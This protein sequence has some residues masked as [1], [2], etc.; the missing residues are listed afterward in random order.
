VL[1]AGGLTLVLLAVGALASVRHSNSSRPGPALDSQLVAVLPFRVSSGDSALSY[2]GE[3]F[4]DLLAVQLTG[5]GGL[6]AAEPRNVLEAW[7]RETAGDLDAEPGFRAGLNV[8]RKIGA[9]R[10]VDGSITGTPHHVVVSAL[11]LETPSGTSVGRA[12]VEGPLE[13]LGELVNR[14][15]AELL[16]TQA[17]ERQRLNDLSVLSL[18]ALRPY[19]EGQAALRQGRWDVAAQ[20]FDAALDVDSTFAQA[21]LGLAEAAEWQAAGDG[22]KGERLA[23]AHRDRLSPG[24]RELLGVHLGP[25]YPGLST[26]AEMIAAAERGVKA[27]PNQPGAWFRLGDRYYHW[28]A[29]IG[30]SHARQLAATAFRRAIQLDSSI[31]RNAPKAEPLTHLFQ[32]AA[33]EGDTATVRR[34][35]PPVPAADSGPGSFPWRAAWVFHD[36]SAIEAIH[37]RFAAGDVNGLEG[38]MTRTLEDG[39]PLNEA[40][41][42]VAALEA[43]A[44][45]QGEQARAQYARYMVAISGGRPMEAVAALRDL[46]P[47]TRFYHGITG[48]LYWDGDTA[49]ARAIARAGAVRADAPLTQVPR[50]LGSQFWQMCWV[51]RWRVAHG[52]LARAGKTIARLRS[53]VTLWQDVADSA[54]TSG[55]G[56]LCADLLEATVATI[57]HRPGAALL[58]TRLN[59]RLRTVP[60]GWTDGDNLAVAHLLE[61]HGNVAEALAAVRRRRFDLVPV[62]LSTYLREEGRLAALA[63]DTTGAIVAYRHFLI[64]QAHPEPA[65]IARLEEIKSDLGRLMQARSARP[66]ARTKM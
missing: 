57:E 46:N 21:A 45:N 12:S 51:E 29:A 39:L 49:F 31:T 66:D 7:R 65:R 26:M 48:E 35:S 15:T 34:L 52:Q 43:H 1:L 27:M 4:V 5:E 41:R 38:V 10:V 14:L 11:M 63:G 9:G 61:A 33:I 2:L 64:L 25:H 60:P 32:I 55:F 19:L 22:G 16:A 28:G 24:D 58:V 62:F 59:D 37:A 44:T 42:A 20:R 23:W 13:N 3:G 50:E 8:A 54:R 36:S 30:L 18:P 53:P 40:E 6:R 17:G 56:T 47:G